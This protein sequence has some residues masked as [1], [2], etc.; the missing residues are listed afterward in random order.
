MS[1]FNNYIPD[2]ADLTVNEIGEIE[3]KQTALQEMYLSDT[4]LYKNYVLVM[5]NGKLINTDLISE[6]LLT[7]HNQKQTDLV[8]DLLASLKIVLTNPAV[9]TLNNYQ[10]NYLIRKFP[11]IDNLKD[12][13]KIF[14]YLDA[15]DNAFINYLVD[16]DDI[17]PVFDEHHINAFDL[18]S[19]LLNDREDF[20]EYLYEK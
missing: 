6:L 8:N 17:R 15:V 5:P 14:N 18:Y 4:Y 16:F 10:T 11:E 2:N 1:L 12:N 13:D 20:A 3:S 19:E 9:N 7:L